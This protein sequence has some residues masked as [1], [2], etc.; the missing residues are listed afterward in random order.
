MKEGLESKLKQQKILFANEVQE[1]KKMLFKLNI[2][3]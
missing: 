3:Y 2:K 1:I